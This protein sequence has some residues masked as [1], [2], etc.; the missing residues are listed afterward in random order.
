V[1]E[2]KAAAPAEKA[3]APGPEA[4]APGTSKKQSLILMVLAVVNMLVI[5]G[6]GFMIYQGR[7][8]DAAEPKIDQVIKGE[9]ETQEKEKKEAAITGKVIP[10]DTFLVNFAGSKGRR[11]AKVN[12]EME[13]EGE[14]VVS[15]ID[16]RKAQV[17]DIIIILLSGKTYDQVSN[18]EG[19][20][21]LKEQIRDTVNAFLTKGKIKEVYFT[22]FI[23]N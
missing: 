8:K 17:R 6:V 4:G 18:R 5:F 1:A 16:Q 23:Y 12:M 19:K 15:E 22:E 9:A 11:V 7:K 2:E 3:A 10:L 14:G 13:V 20:D 21:K